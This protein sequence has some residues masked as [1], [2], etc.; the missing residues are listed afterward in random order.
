MPT[1]S[2]RQRLINLI[3]TFSQIDLPKIATSLVRA[4]LEGLGEEIARLEEATSRF[5]VHIRSEQ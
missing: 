3:H 2:Q 5:L 4:E 1:E